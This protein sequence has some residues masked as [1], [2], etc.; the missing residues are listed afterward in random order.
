MILSAMANGD[1]PPRSHLG[2]APDCPKCFQSRHVRIPMKLQ[3]VAGEDGFDSFV[4]PSCS[5]AMPDRRKTRREW[6]V[7]VKR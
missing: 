3:G 2:S 1:R 4:C 7:K 5:L 6:E